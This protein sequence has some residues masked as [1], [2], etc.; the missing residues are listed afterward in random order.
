MGS[1]ARLLNS[2][3]HVKKSAIEAV[4]DADELQTLNE[5]KIAELT[6][7]H[8]RNYGLPSHVA[9]GGRLC[10]SHQ[11]AEK[12]NQ[13]TSIK[14]LWTAQSPKIGHVEQR[15]GRT[16]KIG[17]ENHHDD[18]EEDDVADQ[19]GHVH[20]YPP[21][22]SANQHAGTQSAAERSTHVFGK[23]EFSKLS[24]SVVHFVLIF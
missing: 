21:L 10:A 12:M 24:Y 17:Q 11:D 8:L 18:V 14:E 3:A 16:S 9:G 1:D 4:L 23:P 20:P 6:N 13:R 22:L 2:L 15:K 5:C 19:G 7:S